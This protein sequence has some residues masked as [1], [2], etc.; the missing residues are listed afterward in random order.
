MAGTAKS[1]DP[2]VENPGLPSTLTSTATN[3]D[4]PDAALYVSD[5]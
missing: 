5:W 3:P 4:S 1:D 2:L